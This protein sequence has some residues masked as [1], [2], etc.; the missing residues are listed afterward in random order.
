LTN[1]NALK[2]ISLRV[3]DTGG[4]IAKKVF[5]NIFNSFF[6]T[7]HIRTGLRLSIYS[8]NIESHGGTIQV[9]N[10]LGK[11]VNVYLHLPLQNSPD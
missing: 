5:E 1:L 10:Q 3:E 4:G 6:T 11:G 7:K 8:K 9:E 2:A